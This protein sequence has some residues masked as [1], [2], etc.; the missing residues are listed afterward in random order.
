LLLA[1]TSVPPVLVLVLKEAGLRQP[2]GF[3]LCFFQECRLLDVS[4]PE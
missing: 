2:R 4:I 3:R 1:A